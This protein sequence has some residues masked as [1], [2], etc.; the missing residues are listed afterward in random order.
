VIFS[1]FNLK[2]GLVE[3][4]R[5]DQGNFVK[6]IAGGGVAPVTKDDFTGSIPQIPYQHIH[7]F[8]IAADNS[9]KM[10][11]NRLSVNVAYQHN[12]REEFGNPD[13]LRERGLS[14]DLQTITYTAQFHV[15]EMNGWF[16]SFGVNG[17]KQENKNKGIEQLIPDYDLFDIGGYFFT[18][19]TI[20][21]ITVSGGAR[22]DNRALTVKAL[23]NG[24]VIKG[25]AFDQSFGNFSGSLGMAAEITKNV[26]LKLNVARGFRAPSIPELASNGAHEG[27]IR[28]EYGDQALKS[29]ISTQADAG[30]DFNTEH[31][32]FSVGAYYNSFNNFIFYKKLQAAG[33]GDSTINVD[34]DDLDAFKFDQRKATLAGLEA[35]IDIHPHPLD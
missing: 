32:S 17:M 9:I 24:A 8:K 15:K 27:T 7:H 33:G 12:Q 22:Y 14:F 34:G 3:G 21:K 5:D 25:A 1:N 20:R 16:T 18:K 28:Y 29:E 31:I 2:T 11:N 30:V 26:N 13:D 4:D 6:P 23:M 19:K 35:T 10:G